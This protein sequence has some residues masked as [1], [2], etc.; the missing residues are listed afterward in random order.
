MSQTS[1]KFRLAM[2][3]NERVSSKKLRLVPLHIFLRI[4]DVW[5]SDFR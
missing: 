4:N 5:L 3:N 1:L 2:R